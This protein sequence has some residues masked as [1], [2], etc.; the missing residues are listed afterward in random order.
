MSAARQEVKRPTLS[1]QGGAATKKL[2]I[3]SQTPRN[4]PNQAGGRGAQV[5]NK[6]K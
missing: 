3:Q 1:W 6:P 2:P 4:R 5:P